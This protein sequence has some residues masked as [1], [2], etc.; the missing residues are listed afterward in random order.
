FAPVPHRQQSTSPRETGQHARADVR[1]S[2]PPRGLDRAV[3][4]GIW[5][6]VLRRHCEEPGL[7]HLGRPQGAARPRAPRICTDGHGGDGRSD[8]GGRGGRRPPGA[9]RALLPRRARL[10]RALLARPRALARPRRARTRS[11]GH[12]GH[13]GHGSHGGHGGHNGG[14]GGHGGGHGGYGGGH[15]GHGGGHG[16]SLFG[17]GHGGGHGGGHGW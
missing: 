1:R 8:T 10:P 12:G 5:Q 3:R 13:G 17:F 9:R 6:N 15:E 4:P 11:C 7:H 16:F 14:H 2:A